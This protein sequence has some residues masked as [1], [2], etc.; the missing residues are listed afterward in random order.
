MRPIVTLPILVYTSKLVYR[1]S[2][3]LKTTKQF[4]FT[5]KSNW[6]ILTNCKTKQ[7]RIGLPICVH[8]TVFG[9]TQDFFFPSIF[10]QMY[11]S[12]KLTQVLMCELIRDGFLSILLIVVSFYTPHLLLPLC[13][14]HH[15]QRCCLQLH[16]RG[17]RQ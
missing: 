10:L 17:D 6:H 4:L 9:K 14:H 5:G 15:P 11:N 8:C 7:K 3:K 1:V 13:S 16:C 2:S 12:L